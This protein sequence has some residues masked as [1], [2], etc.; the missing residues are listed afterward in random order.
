[1]ECINDYAYAGE[2]SLE[3]YE[4]IPLG[5]QGDVTQK[6]LISDHYYMGGTFKFS[7]KKIKHDFS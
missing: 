3:S 6:N 4:L 2:F 1:V 5:Q 7:I